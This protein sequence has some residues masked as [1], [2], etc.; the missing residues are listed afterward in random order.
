[1]S[2][3]T[4][5]V[6]DVAEGSTSDGAPLVQ[7]QLQGSANQIFR[8]EPTDSGWFRIVALHSGKCLTVPNASL[9]SGVQ[10]VQATWEGGLHQQFSDAGTAKTH[11]RLRIRHTTVPGARAKAVDLEGG[12]SALG[13]RIIQWDEFGGSGSPNQLWRWDTASMLPRHAPLKAATGGS[14]NQQIYLSNSPGTQFRIEGLAGGGNGFYRITPGGLSSL[15]LEVPNDSRAGQ[16]GA[17]IQWGVWGSTGAATQMWKI[18]PVDSG[19][20]RI[21]NANSGKAIDVTGGGTTDGTKLV[22]WS[23]NG[24]ANQMWKL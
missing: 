24:G 20:H 6:L 15:V 9:Q 16:D 2:G 17:P 5:G 23:I 1:M 22:Q 18:Q 4:G 10:L 13:A 14:R 3:M 7:W 8:F 11:R 19:Y 21:L 12:S